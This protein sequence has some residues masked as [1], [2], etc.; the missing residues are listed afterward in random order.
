M[1]IPTPKDRWELIKL[2]DDCPDAQ[3]WQTS[4]EFLRGLLE[5]AYLAEKAIDQAIENSHHAAV[6]RDILLEALDKIRGC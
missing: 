2:M 5:L 1:K 6:S 3:A 4:Y